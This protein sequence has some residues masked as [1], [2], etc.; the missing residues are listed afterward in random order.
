[1][2]E[3]LDEQALPANKDRNTMSSDEIAARWRRQGCRRI[4]GVDE[5]GRGPLAGPVVAAAVI[6]P[7][8]FDAAGITDSKALP[9]LRREALA[10]RI[11]ESAEVA[12]AYVPAPVIDRLNIHGATLL[13]MRRAI[14]ALPVPPDAVLCDGKFVPK[15][16]SCPG[17]AVIKGDSKV[18]AIAAASIVA[19]VA[20]D[21]M[22]EAA[23]AQFPGYF[24]AKNAGYPAPVHKA[25]LIDIGLC[26]LH[27]LSFAPCRAVFEATTTG[28]SEKGQSA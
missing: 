3:P 10:R 22:M 27:R 26:P 20:R 4:A 25:A 23:E 11:T 16:L 2:P 13:A 28:R 9:P 24:F 21:M 19:K 14:E 5:V 7:A 8:G 1:M 15:G 18:L 6:L 12:I 17:E